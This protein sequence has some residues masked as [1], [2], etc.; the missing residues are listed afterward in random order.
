M[1]RTIYIGG[2]AGLLITAALILA[3]PDFNAILS[4]AQGALNLAWPRGGS[5]VAWTDRWIVVIGCAIVVGSGLLYMVLGR[6][7]ARGNS[8]AGDAV[9]AR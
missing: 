2:A 9:S 5:D 3:Q 1:R 6:P 7:Y 8:P 4:G